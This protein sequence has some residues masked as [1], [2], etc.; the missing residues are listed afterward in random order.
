M[1]GMLRVLML[2]DNPD[3]AKAMAI[4]LEQW[5]YVLMWERVDDQQRFLAALKRKWDLILADYSLPY[6]Y[7]A[8][9]ALP[10]L[11]MI[12]CDTPLI[13]VTGTQPHH[14]G[15]LLIRDG[16]AAYVP[17][18]DLRTLGPMTDKAL[19]QLYKDRDTRQTIA[20]QREELEEEGVDLELLA[21][22]DQALDRVAQQ[23]QPDADKDR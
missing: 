4:A 19:D 21:K 10:A 3:D 8:V 2:E 11:R 18:D 23:V 22:I 7:G 5:G 17:K 9:Q 14:V 16:A 20:S 12:G 15:D 13:V 6:G 1:K